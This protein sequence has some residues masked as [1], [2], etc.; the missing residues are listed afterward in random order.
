MNIKNHFKNQ[1]IALAL[2]TSVTVLFT[3]CKKDSL[4]EP[5][6]EQ[7]QTDILP[8]GYTSEALAADGITSN[9]FYLENALPSGYVKDGSRDYTSQ[10]QAA[11][12]KYSNIVFPGFPIMV[13]DAGI[14][15]GSNK[16]ITFQK[17]SELRLK[18]SSQA[19]YDILNIRKSTNITLYNPVIV[20][21]RKTHIGTSGEWGMGIGIRGS[22][23]ITIHN[24]KI[25]DCWGDGIYIG[26]ADDLYCKNIVIT[27]AYLRNNRRDGISII[28]V[29]GLL[30][31]NI[32][33]GYNA[34]TSPG[35][36]INFEPNNSKCELKNIRI[37][38]PHTEFNGERGIQITAHHILDNNAVKVSDLTIVNHIDEGSPIAAFKVSLNPKDGSLGTMSGLINIINPSWRRTANNRPLNVLTNQLNYKIKISTP[39]I[40]NAAGLTLSWADVYAL[41]TKAGS[42]VSVTNVVDPLAA[43]PPADA[44]PVS[45][46]PTTTVASGTVVFA[47]NAGGGSFTASNGISYSTDKNYVGGSVYKVS[48]AIANTTDDVL[49]QSERYGNFSYSI[50]LANGT[51]EITFKTAELFHKFSGK[52]RF[53]IL[54]ENS[55]IVSNLDVFAVAGINNSFD[56]VKSVTVSDGTLNLSFRTDINNATVSAFHIIKK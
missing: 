38:N 30:L 12:S 53:D 45:P 50:P 49:Y 10:I 19:G 33:A 17:G 52:R 55:E 21:D 42:N 24:P 27:D 6:M 26:Q 32:Y 34:G 23:N 25:T 37:N 9:S 47:V 2:L 11:V 54:A 35:V 4:D 56:L 8:E 29:D 18:S 1:I 43:V 16:T 31:D 20:G 51:Y 14:T 39:S 3:N 44:L 5:Q 7:P 41:L 48:T 36:G 13:N 15:I 22:S 28:A 46:L 40:I